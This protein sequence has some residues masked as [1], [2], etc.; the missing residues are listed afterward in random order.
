MIILKLY[1][2]EKCY[3]MSK[4]HTAQWAR[5]LKNFFL[6]KNTLLL[7]KYSKMIFLKILALLPCEQ[8]NLKQ[9]SKFTLFLL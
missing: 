4:V 9:Y 2:I 3:D 7:H 1:K 5:K 8:G 6:K